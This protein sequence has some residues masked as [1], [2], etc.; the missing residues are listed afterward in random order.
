MTNQA[1]IHAWS[2][3]RNGSSQDEQKVL[4]AA[5]GGEDHLPVNNRP[6]TD[7]AARPEPGVRGTW[8]TQSSKRTKTRWRRH[9]SVTEQGQQGALKFRPTLVSRRHDYH[10]KDP[11]H[12]PPQDGERPRSSGPGLVRPQPRPMR[13]SRR[14]FPLWPPFPAPSHQNSSKNTRCL[15]S[16]RHGQAPCRHGREELRPSADRAVRPSEGK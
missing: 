3:N 14:R 9:G 11:L 10:W 15:V 6:V 5:R 7:R 2:G 16:A 8:S 13:L 12:A 4:K 1:G